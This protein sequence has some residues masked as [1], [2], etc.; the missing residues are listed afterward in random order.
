MNNAGRSGEEPEMERL[1][2]LTG[3]FGLIFI[4]WLLSDN[5]KKIDYRMVV[6]GVLLQFVFA[7]LVLK[8]SQGRW[9]FDGAQEL[10]TRLIGFSDAGAQFM[11]GDN[12][13][14]HFFA[15]SVLPT[16]IFISSIMSV[17]FYF[18]I[19]QQIV[20]AMAWVMVR[21]MNVSGSESLAAS[22]N[23]FVGQTEAPLVIKPYI[24]SMTN[25][26]LMALMVGGMANIAGGVMAAYVQFGADAGHLLA[27]SVMSAPA[28][29]VIAK[30][31]VPE[32]GESHTKGTVKI[33]VPVTDTNALDAA[34]R[35]ASEGLSLALN[36]GAMLI[37][38]VAFSACLNY[39]LGVFGDVGGAPLTFERILGVAFS[40]IAWL[41]GVP[42]NDC[43]AV[44]ALLGKKMFLNEFVAY[45]DLKTL[46]GVISER[47]F[48]LSTYAL[49]GFANFSSI[50]I[51][52]GGIG[53][54]I[55]SRRQDLAR[56]GFLSMIGGTIATMMTAT[57][58]GALL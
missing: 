18:G 39:M 5:K 30:I 16:I 57:I 52:I 38:F 20:K 45:M 4:A 9:F 37:A 56:L 29:L 43:L 2:S 11:F 51:Q 35:G 23:V 55:P 21:V 46:K 58:A 10:V 14:D 42:W 27:A 53:A 19:M 33:D 15:F 12:F 49:C 48:T 54:L 50:A 1:I 41:I 22:V 13:R 28:S 44:G 17:F 32:V 47:S 36:V 34:C 8:T 24:A 25:S 31:M 26:E 7:V 3:L 6:S 40:P